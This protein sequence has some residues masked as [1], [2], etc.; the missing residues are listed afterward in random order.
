MTPEIF[1]VEQFMIEPQSAQKF[2][3]ILEKKSYGI[4]PDWR[5][6][7]ED[8]IITSA[9]RCLEELDRGMQGAQFLKTHGMLH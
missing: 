6:M 8:Q 2:L 1:S 5:E 9:I 3:S 4:V 7:T